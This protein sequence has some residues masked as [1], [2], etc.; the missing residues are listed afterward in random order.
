M[1]DRSSAA[2][3]SNTTK[4]FEIS[5]ISGYWSILKYQHECRIRYNTFT[6]VD[7][8]YSTLSMILICCAHPVTWLCSTWRFR[9]RSQIRAL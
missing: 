3:Y 4:T 7:L 8:T 6:A 9:P 5:P 1:T 2:V